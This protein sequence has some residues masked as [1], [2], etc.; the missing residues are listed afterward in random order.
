M[1]KAKKAEIAQKYLD[2]LDE[3]WARQSGRYRDSLEEGFKI[4]THTAQIYQCELCWKSM[5]CLGLKEPDP[6]CACGRERCGSCWRRARRKEDWSLTP[7]PW[8]R[9]TSVKSLRQQ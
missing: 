1:E 8:K 4:C 9:H 5:V 3:E 2:T 7:P 6:D